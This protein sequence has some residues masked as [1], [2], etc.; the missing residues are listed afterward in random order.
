MAFGDSPALVTGATGFI[1][2][3]LTGRLTAA[4]VRVRATGRTPPSGRVDPAVEFLAA[5]L[6]DDD[7]VRR[8][9]DG[10][11]A[12]FH[13]AGL[14]HRVTGP[15][16]TLDE[17]RTLNVEATRRLLSAAI[18]GG[19]RCIVFA[20]TVKA[21]GEST[22]GCVDETAPPHPTTP[23]GQSK[24]EAEGLLFAEG[25]RAG[26]H[27]TCLR[28]PM[29]YGVGNRGNLPR[30]IAA[31][32]QGRFPPLPRVSAR[33][34]MVHVANVC[35]AALCAATVPVAAGQSYIVTDADAY[36]T[37]EVYDLVRQGLGLAVPRWRVPAAAL[38]CG[39]I[40]G[41]WMAALTGRRMPFDSS[42][43]D[44]LLGPS[45]Y[46]SAKAVRE[47]GYRPVLGLKDALPEIIAEYRR[48]A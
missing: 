10:V 3:A 47:L 1:G 20:S 44:K 27:V 39:A 48:K 12:I 33:R 6:T 34:S 8:V 30:M 19:A 28:L 42:S 29:V 37:S 13:F 36:T 23:Y 7:A 15:E 32:D 2:R 43:Y 40:A 46:S 31:I 24:L 21:I 26:I 17:F 22:V 14:A 16:P 18:R 45:W 11:G 41:D 25:A 38:R 5:D 9:C 4:G 35:E